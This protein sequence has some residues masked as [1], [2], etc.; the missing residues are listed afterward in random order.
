MQFGI[1]DHLDRNDADLGEF[2]EQRLG[3][4]EEYDRLGFYCYHLAEHHGTPLGMSPS[5]GIFLS[6]VAQRTRTLRF[7]PLVYVLPLYH[8]VRLVEEICMLD[9]LSKGRF[10]LGIGKGISSHLESVM[11]D[12]D[13]AEVSDRYQE[14]FEVLRRGLTEGVVDFQGQRFHFHNVPFAVRPRQLPHP[15]LWYGVGGPDSCAWAARN[16]VNVVCNLPTAAVRPVTDRY[17]AEW[18]AQGNAAAMP[19]VGMNRHVV[20]ADTD[21]EA[22]SLARRAFATWYVSFMHL[23]HKSGL[24]PRQSYPDTFDEAAA[25]GMAVAGAPE[26]VARLLAAQVRETGVNY[27][28]VRLAFG[29]LTPEQVRHSARLFA[30]H[31]MPAIREGA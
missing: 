31:A 1:F 16:A 7:G 28:L 30:A 20:I 24:R 27:L 29:D 19:L 26:T 23:W 8:P 25:F 21:A 11:Y 9:Q 15:P 17:R 12:I 5:P 4:I 22:L 2:Y 13:N 14:C 6:A 3:L 18:A 10:Q